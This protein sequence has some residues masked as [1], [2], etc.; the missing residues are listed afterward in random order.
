[1]TVPG[2]AIILAGGLG[3]RLKN[4]VADRPKPMAPVAG[5]PFLEYLIKYLTKSGISKIILS[6]GFRWEI[7]HDYF[8]NSHSGATIEYAIENEPLGT[9]GGILNALNFSTGETIFLVNGDT[10]FHID[11]QEFTKFHTASNADLSVALRRMKDGSRYGTIS[12]ASDGRILEFLEKQE[13]SDHVLINGGIYILSRNAF[14]QKTFPKKFS[15]EK[16]F[17]ESSYKNQRFFGKEFDDYFIDIGIPDT[18][19]QAQTDF[20]HLFA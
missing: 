5:K 18:F 12:T 3:T 10:F 20:H 19:R 2:E 14:C 17:L 1:M 11:L 4:V 9:G 15:F 7:I 8:G 13:N 16:D 6:V